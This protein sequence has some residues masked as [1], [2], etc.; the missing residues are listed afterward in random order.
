MTYAPIETCG[1]AVAARSAGDHRAVRVR[2]VRPADAAAI[3]AFVRGLSDATRRLRFFAPVR[4]LTPGMLKRLTEVE[5]GPDQV[6]V[7]FAGAGG[8]ARIVALAQYAVDADGETCEVALVIADEWQG[9]GLGRLL[10]AELVE[11]AREAGMTR[12]VGDVLRGND[13]M[14]GLARASGFEVGHSHHDATMFRIRR[15]LDDA[16]R[17]PVPSE[18][19]AGA[20]ATVLH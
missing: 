14:L 20:P 5:G 1:S 15:Y 13:A 11:S 8:A 7:C 3:Q 2:P 6:L 12:I 4:E 17:A 18:S 9:R 19:A 10:L 16:A